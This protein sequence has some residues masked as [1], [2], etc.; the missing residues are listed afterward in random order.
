MHIS[1]LSNFTNL[2]KGNLGQSVQQS[3]LVQDHQPAP[4]RGPPG[5]SCTGL[6]TPRGQESAIHSHSGSIWVMKLEDKF[7]SLPSISLTRTGNSTP[8]LQAPGRLPCFLVL[9]TMAQA[10]PSPRGPSFLSLHHAQAVSEAQCWP[11][12]SSPLLHRPW[13]LLSPEPLSPKVRAPLPQSPIV[14]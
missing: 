3:P 10:I 2:S 8:P 13:Y 5:Q 7:L 12:S 4:P 11:P 6:P 1:L 9:P 14:P